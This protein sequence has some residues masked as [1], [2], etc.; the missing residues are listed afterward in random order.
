MSDE[1]IVLTS[2]TYTARAASIRATSFASVP[3]GMYARVGAHE[4]PVHTI[5]LYDGGRGG[6]DAAR[7]CELF[8]TAA[9]DGAVKLWE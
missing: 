7:G 6:G 2:P 1:G 9:L 5:S 8:V 3:P 4:R